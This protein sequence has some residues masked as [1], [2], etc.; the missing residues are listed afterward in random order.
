MS[1]ALAEA[2]R[3]P[4][5]RYYTPD[6]LARVL[7]GLLPLY[8]S[9]VVVE[10]SVGGG[11]F[12]R[13][14]R[15]QVPRARL[16]GVDIDPQAAGFQDCH[17]AAIAGDFLEHSLVGLGTPD[18]VIGNPPYR[19]ALAHLM[20]A[21]GF[22]SRVAFLLRMGFLG[23]QT[24]LPFWKSDGLCLEKVYALAQRPSFT[25]EGTD[26]ADY[27]FFIFN[28]RHRGPA[29]LQVLDWRGAA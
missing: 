2:Q 6:E 12:A 22:G 16:I 8:S 3:R 21:L 27:G 4:G 19:K 17:T 26:S 1:S 18:W 23:S 20:H 24:R 14:I 9:D 25:G 15:A 28:P 13:A 7:V 5:D 11:A 10:P 29:Q